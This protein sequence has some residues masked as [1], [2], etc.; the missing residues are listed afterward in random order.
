WTKDGIYIFITCGIYLHLTSVVI[1]IIK[2]FKAE[3]LNKRYANEPTNTMQYFYKILNSPNLV[4]ELKSIAIQDFVVEN[5][6]FWENYCILQKLVTRVKQKQ[7]ITV[8]SSSNSHHQKFSLQDIYSQNSGSHDEESY[9]P[10][11]PLLPQLVPY[12]NAFYH[13][14]IDVDGP[15][16]VNISGSTVRRIYHDFYTYPTVGIFDEAKDEV[17]E[18]MFVTIFPALLQNNRKQLGELYSQNI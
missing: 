8:D 14:F 18:S 2:C 1:P 9:D 11:Y 16:V 17:V 13:T 12:Y 7:D 4:E 6:L 10:N 5:V 3:R 15:A